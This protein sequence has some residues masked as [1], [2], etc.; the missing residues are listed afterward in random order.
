MDP[1]R[2]HAYKARASKKHKGHQL[3]ND[4]ILYS[5]TA[6]ACTSFCSSPLW[7]PPFCATFNV[8]FFLS[9]PKI[10]S[11]FFTSKALFIVGNLIVIF[12][13]GESK[14]FASKSKDCNDVC[15]DKYECTHLD[16]LRLTTPSHEPN[17]VKKVIDTPKHDIQV[18][19]LE[20]V[21]CEA[22]DQE[23][24]F[25]LCND[26]ETCDLDENAAASSRQDE[27]EVSCSGRE[28]KVVEEGKQDEDVHLPA[29]ELNK[30]VDDF[31]A[32]IIRQ[33]RL[34]DEFCRG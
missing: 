25:E 9:L 10:T 30:L 16:K 5:L 34:E 27:D 24:F 20:L 2:I 12:L 23:E 1:L 13:L 28:I 6:L 32:R 22:N 11:F 26:E 8:F 33:R 7:Y 4:F 18:K 14:F 31:I 17:K 29:E 21:T 15:H 19:N 3:L